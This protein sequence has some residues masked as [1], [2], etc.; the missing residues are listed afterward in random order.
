MINLYLFNTIINTIWYIFTILFVL[1]K[2]TSFFT[3]M[4]NFFKFCGK[5]FSWTGYIYD[6]IKIY[7]NK[8]KG[9]TVLQNETNIQ[10]NSNISFFQ[11]TKNYMKNTYHYYTKKWFGTPR[12]TTTTLD[13]PLTETVSTSVQTNIK[14]E[15]YYNQDSKEQ[16]YFDQHINKLNNSSIFFNKYY[17]NKDSYYDVNFSTFSTS[18]NNHNSTFYGKDILSDS[19][20]YEKDNNKMSSNLTNSLLRK[21]INDDNDD[22]TP[23]LTEEKRPYNV[24]NSNMLFNSEF[25][26]TNLTAIN[27]VPLKRTT[28]FIDLEKDKKPKI[29]FLSHSVYN[30]ESNSENDLQ[31]T[32]NNNPYI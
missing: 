3:Y 32:I 13:I 4:Y 10:N 7:L 29:D 15:S 8:R 31:D 30:K 25:I 14:N 11:R 2:F 27:V 5:L 1:Y 28:E 6:Q 20:F 21:K 19:T 12:E 26:Q 22:I 18:Y 17:D 24:D 9:Y 16:D 23:L